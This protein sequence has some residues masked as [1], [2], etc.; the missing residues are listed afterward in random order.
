MSGFTAM[1]EK[2]DPEVVTTLMNDYFEIMNKLVEYY[3]GVITNY[4]GDDMMAVFGVPHAI[5]N[6]PQKGVNCA[7][8]IRNK[9]RQFNK[10][11]RGLFRRV[12]QRERLHFCHVDNALPGVKVNRCNRK[13]HKQHVN[14]CLRPCLAAE[15]KNKR[16]IKVLPALEHQSPEFEVKGVGEPDPFHYLPLFCP[17]VEHRNQLCFLPFSSRIIL[18]AGISICSIIFLFCWGVKKDIFSR[19]TFS[20][21]LS[22]LS[23]SS[24]IV[25]RTLR[26]FSCLSRVILTVFNPSFLGAGTSIFNSLICDFFSSSA[27]LPT[28]Q[29]LG[30]SYY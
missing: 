2:T 1:S 27:M 5:E 11:S 9:I 30:I 4:Q 18:S 14:A 15:R 24:R 7:I 19:L 28:L 29:V 10:E 26:I 22:I 8:E 21:I 17:V 25:S 6:A 23:K 12:V 13:E 16:V 3:Q 20:R